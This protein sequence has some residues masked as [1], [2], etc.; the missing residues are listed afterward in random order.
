[1]HKGGVCVQSF[2][3]I[4]IAAYR[5]SSSVRSSGVVAV[6]SKLAMGWDSAGAVPPHAPRS[7]PLYFDLLG[8]D[9]KVCQDI[10][11]VRDERGEQV[12]VAYCTIVT[13]VPSISLAVEITRELAW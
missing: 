4:H 11:H 2:I 12:Y 9:V 7:C 6:G 8:R 3:A 5:C 1:M 13:S 10:C